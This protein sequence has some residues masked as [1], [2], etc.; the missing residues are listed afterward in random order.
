MYRGNSKDVEIVTFDEL[1]VKL[2]LLHS[3]LSENEWC[4]SV[5]LKHN[6][7]F[8]PKL[9]VEVCARSV[10]YGI[11]VSVHKFQA[12]NTTIVAFSWSTIWRSVL[13]KLAR[14]K[15]LRLDEK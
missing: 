3:L 1:L 6:V 8:W 2:K 11:N 7:R 5:N 9:E 12:L 15:S 13:L 14:G 10:H 4:I